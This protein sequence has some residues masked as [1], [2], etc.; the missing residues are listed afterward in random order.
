VSFRERDC[1]SKST[2]GRA[3]KPA[4][5]NKE[6]QESVKVTLDMVLNYTQCDIIFKLYVLLNFL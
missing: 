3:R 6:E 2:P 1:T 4:T 5:L